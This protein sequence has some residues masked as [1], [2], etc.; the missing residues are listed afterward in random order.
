MHNQNPW[1]TFLAGGGGGGHFTFLRR[2]V[3]L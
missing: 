2:V 3:P 1:A